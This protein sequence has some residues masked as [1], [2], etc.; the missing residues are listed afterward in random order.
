MTKS[1]PVRAGSR[2][3]CGKLRMA[4]QSR[5][6]DVDDGPV[7]I[8]VIRRYRAARRP[9]PAPKAPPR[10]GVSVLA[11]ALAFR[12]AI[13]DPAIGNR[14]GLARRL[15]VSRAHITQAMAILEAPA[16]VL[17][18]IE[19]AERGGRVVTEGLWRGVRAVDPAAGS[20]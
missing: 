20:R 7:T 15:G 5:T 8:R 9:E 18:A 2:G 10:V 4:V 3:K 6:P 1:Q 13:A 14:A 17:A 16:E 19:R 12:E 11:R